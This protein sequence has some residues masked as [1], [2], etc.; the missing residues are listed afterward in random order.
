MLKS[1]SCSRNRRRRR[2]DVVEHGQA[3][4]HGAFGVVLMG[5]GRAK[6]GEEPVACELAYRALKALDGFDELLEGLI[7]DFGPDFGV[8]RFGHGR[9]A[10]DIAE[11]H[12]DDAALAARGAR[13]CALF[14][15]GRRGF[16]AQSGQFLAQGSLGSVYDGVAQAAALG[17]EGDYGLL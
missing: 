10:G 6:E 2:F 7:H 5:R 3:G 13:G 9:G 17:F 16:A 15:F 4:E 12:G 1:S 14:T 11:E 8:Q